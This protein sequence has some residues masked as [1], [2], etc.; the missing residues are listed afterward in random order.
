MPPASTAI[1]HA[2]IARL[3]AL[4]AG[5]LDCGTG[6]GL[7]F[8]PEKVLP[9]MRVP[10]PTEE[11]LVYLRFVG[12]FVAAVGSTYLWA[13][14]RGGIGRLR[15][16]LEFTI[17]FRLAAGSFCTVC[18]VRGWLAPAW[19]SVPASD[20]ALVAIQLWLVT[21]LSIL[22]VRASSPSSL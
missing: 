15:D 6:V 14:L 16:M 21:K 19:S 8:L 1:N 10:V 18:I 7:V 11:A 3:L 12:A 22:D 4:F 13:L 2:R 9:L 5:L 20:F 17:L